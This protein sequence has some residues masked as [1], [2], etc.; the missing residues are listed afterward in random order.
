VSFGASIFPIKNLNR[1]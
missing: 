1:I